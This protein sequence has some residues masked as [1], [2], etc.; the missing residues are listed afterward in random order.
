MTIAT[1]SWKIKVKPKPI[2][3]KTLLRSLPLAKLCTNNTGPNGTAKAGCTT[4]TTYGCKVNGTIRLK[5]C[6]YCTDYAYH[7]KPATVAGN[8]WQAIRFDHTNLFAGEVPGIRFNPSIIDSD[9]GFIFA[10]RNGWQGSRIYLCRLT[11]DF[12]P[13]PASWVKLD[14]PTRGTVGHEDPRLFRLNGK[15]HC[16]YTA[17]GGKRTHVKFARINEAT[18][19]VEDSFFPQLAGR[20]SWEKNWSC[21]D[22][23]G[24]THA[25]YDTSPNHRIIKI[26]GDKAS[27][28][29]STPF[30]GK[31]S[32]GFMRGGASP[33]MVDGHWWHFFHGSTTHKG[34]RRY[35][36]GVTVFRAEPPFDIVKY[37]PDPIDEADTERKHDC[38][39]D[40][41]F[42]GGAVHKDGRFI[43]ASGI[44]DRW[45]E[46]RFYDKA[47]IESQ[48][49]CPPSQ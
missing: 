31:W 48:L 37:T 5:D 35:N 16:A 10:F 38:Y 39:C 25:V 36:T 13:V 33:I 34:R 8:S 45:A 2:V 42:V 49:I 9:D 47:L 20:Q 22:Y 21:F 29:H 14:L 28:A 24:I 27:W 30:T 23:Q 4:C 40:C 3:A 18:L 7:E 15:L 19:Q 11:N 44:H 46:I 41:L 6:V 32:G 1:P 26:E 12:Q 43:T 17:Y